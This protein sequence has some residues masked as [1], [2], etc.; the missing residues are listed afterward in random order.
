MKI[1][2]C[3]KNLIR[4]EVESI[5]CYDSC[6][7]SIIDIVESD[8]VCSNS[9]EK[10]DNSSCSEIPNN[11]I[12]S[13]SMD[14]DNGKDLFYRRLW[15]HEEQMEAAER[16]RVLMNL[17]EQPQ[18]PCEH[19]FKELVILTESLADKEDVQEMIR[20]NGTYSDHRSKRVYSLPPL[21]TCSRCGLVTCNNP[22][23]ST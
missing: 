7:S 4:E 17:L 3:K 19:S 18:S 21:F 11:S 20:R 13:N 8:C 1:C 16:L 23:V 15:T 5:A 12:P 9:P 6:T 22:N 14:K 10:P 2:P